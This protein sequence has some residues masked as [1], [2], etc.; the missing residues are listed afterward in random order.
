MGTENDRAAHYLTLAEGH[1]LKAKKNLRDG[2][3]PV[4]TKE[5]L[6]NAA[7]A[8]RA[9]ERIIDRA[10]EPHALLEGE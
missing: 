6:Q 3:H 4:Y 10:S 1:L 7:A 2:G 5:K 9:A 8:L